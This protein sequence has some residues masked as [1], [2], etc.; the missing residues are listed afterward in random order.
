[1]GITIPLYETGGM[2]KLTGKATIIWDDDHE[3]VD[4][5]EGAKR[6]IPFVID[7][8][9]ELKKGSLPLH[10]DTSSEQTANNPSG[11]A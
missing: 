4:Q 5:Y 6:L 2:I 9:V 3:L 8:V 11:K 10:W 1:M 7:E